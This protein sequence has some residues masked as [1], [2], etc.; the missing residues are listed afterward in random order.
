MKF[1]FFFS[2]L[3]LYFV[4]ICLFLSRS[5]HSVADEMRMKCVSNQFA[6][7]KKK[8]ERH[9]NER[10]RDRTSWSQMENYSML[11]FVIFGP[12]GGIL[13]D[14]NYPHENVSNVRG[15]LN[16]NQQ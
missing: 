5:H 10:E 4:F 14:S 13:P 3:I 12:F 9:A 2:S 7:L 11:N 16:A 15:V 6:N 1:N 8:C